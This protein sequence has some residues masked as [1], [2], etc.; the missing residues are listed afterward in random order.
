VQIIW[1]RRASRQLAVAYAYALETNPSA[2]DRQ[3]TT[4]VRAVE[5][6]SDFPELGRPGRVAGT[7]EWVIQGTPYIVAYRIRTSR[8][9]ILALLHSARRWPEVL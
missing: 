4:L 9:R 6:L 8:V 1:T 5:Q 2:A 3:A 7:R